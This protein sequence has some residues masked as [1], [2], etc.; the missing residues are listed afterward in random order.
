MVYKSR[1]FTNPEG[2]QIL[3]GS[4]ILLGLQI[5]YGLQTLLCL[6]IL[7]GLQ[8]QKVYRSC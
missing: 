6:Q 3:Y 1:R 8:I 5:L 7:L 4:Q 2:L